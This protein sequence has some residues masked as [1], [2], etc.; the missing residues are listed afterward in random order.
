[1]TFRPSAGQRNRMKVEGFRTPHSTG[2]Y[3]FGFQKEAMHAFTCVV[4]HG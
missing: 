1:V 2:S 3:S 4:A